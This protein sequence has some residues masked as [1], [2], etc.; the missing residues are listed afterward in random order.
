LSFWLQQSPVETEGVPRPTLQQEYL[1]ELYSYLLL[2]WQL[3]GLDLTQF[4][5]PA[6]SLSDS[7]PQFPGASG[8]PEVSTEN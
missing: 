1:Q 4:G 6:V 7:E 8:C 3:E 5:H 2:S